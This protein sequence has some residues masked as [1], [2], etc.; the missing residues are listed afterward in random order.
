M[1]FACADKFGSQVHDAIYYSK[2][3]GFYRKTNNAGGIEGG[4]S[5]GENI[6]IRAC[7]KPISTLLNPL[8]SVNINSKK[9]AKAT[10][11]RSDICAVESAGVIAESA[12]AFVLA[13]ALL[14]KF[15]SDALI[16][17]K[18]NYQNYLKRIC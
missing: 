4:V 6:I 16:D 15:G 12:V 1:G 9:P 7:M 5:N 3:K 13:E 14:D 8:D 10:V 2:A 17:I 11:E 18:N